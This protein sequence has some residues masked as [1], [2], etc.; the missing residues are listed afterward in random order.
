MSLPRLDSRGLLP[1]G[2]H[3]AAWDEIRKDFCT[4]GHRRSLFSDL[5]RFV[6]SELR[7]TAVGLRLILGGSFFSDKKSPSDIEAAVFLPNQEISARAPLVALAGKPEHLRIKQEYRVDFYVSFDLAGAP[8]FELFFQ[9]AG[10]KTALMKGLNEK[11]L[12]GIIEVR[13]W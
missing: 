5:H 6:E 9:Y 8:N 12:R 3:A 11:D 10:P 1:A 7:P 13:S 4:S 2:C